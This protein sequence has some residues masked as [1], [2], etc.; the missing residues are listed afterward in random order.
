MEGRDLSRYNPNEAQDYS[1]DPEDYLAVAL[2]EV[3]GAKQHANGL[4]SF[5]PNVL[6]V[7]TLLSDEFFAAIDRQMDLQR[8]IPEPALGTLDALLITSCGVDQP[9]S[10]G[11]LRIENGDHPLISWLKAHN[12]LTPGK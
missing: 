8:A 3:V 2:R 9:M 7:N 5:R 11:T 4:G 10:G 12:L 6:C 1:G